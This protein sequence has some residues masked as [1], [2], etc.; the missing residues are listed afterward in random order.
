MND[1]ENR[2]SEK[3]SGRL[4]A[5]PHCPRCSAALESALHALVF[6]PQIAEI[7]NNSPMASAILRNNLLQLWQLWI[8]VVAAVTNRSEAKFN[9]TG[10]AYLL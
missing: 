4:T 6:C 2:G 9:M 10:I 5:D 7:W 8:D 1:L 3:P